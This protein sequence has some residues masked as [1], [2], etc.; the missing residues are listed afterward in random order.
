M[1]A[2]HW[3]DGYENRLLDL[4]AD[5]GSELDVHTAFD[6]TGQDEG[7]DLYY[8]MAKVECLAHICFLFIV[9]AQYRS[10]GGETRFVMP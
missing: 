5:I 9:E 1:K 8:M 7:L 4:K 2:F 6:R 3:M 10:Y